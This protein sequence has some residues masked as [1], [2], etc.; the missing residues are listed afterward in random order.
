MLVD[1][2]HLSACPKCI[3]VFI[4]QN[5]DI[6]CEML[7]IDSTG[8]ISQK[9]KQLIAD[10]CVLMMM[11]I[12]DDDGKKRLI[13]EVRQLRMFRQIAMNALDTSAKNVLNNPN[14]NP[15][16]DIEIIDEIQSA[17]EYGKQIDK[18]TVTKTEFCNHVPIDPA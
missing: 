8:K 7:R 12:Q 15:D 11:A 14:M 5:M 9:Q 10:V 13:K 1:A 16:R 18:K 6:V 2:T 17:I 3:R 4:E